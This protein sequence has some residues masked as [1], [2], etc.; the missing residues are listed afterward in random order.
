M[1]DDDGLFVR[2][3]GQDDKGFWVLA[4]STF[5]GR[6]SICHCPLLVGNFMADY[7]AVLVCRR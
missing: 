7:L 5:L 3:G 6:F 2:E 4:R 1:K